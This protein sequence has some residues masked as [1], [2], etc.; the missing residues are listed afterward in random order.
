MAREVS[1]NLEINTSCRV[2]ARRGK[3]EIR[4]KR[5]VLRE[6]SMGM[7]GQAEGAHVKRR[8]K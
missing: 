7:Y 5:G 3:V 8:C 1:E 4:W 6:I 2:R